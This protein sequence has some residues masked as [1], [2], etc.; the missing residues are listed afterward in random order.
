MRAGNARNGLSIAA[1]V[2]GSGEVRRLASHCGRTRG[3]NVQVLPKEQARIALF[4]CATG[5]HTLAVRT[6]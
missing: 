2:S 5:P 6:R 1:S 3:Q 4:N